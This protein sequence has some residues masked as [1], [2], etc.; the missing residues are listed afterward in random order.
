MTKTR[1]VNGDIV[2]PWRFEP[3]E[4]QE[5]LGAFVL[6]DSQWETEIESL[7]KKANVFVDQL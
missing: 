7:K 3:K 6:L 1:D 2:T 5:T 4:A